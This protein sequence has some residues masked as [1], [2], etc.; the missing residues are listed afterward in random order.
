MSL[1]Y[2]EFKKIVPEET[3]TFFEQLLPLIDYYIGDY[4]D[5][6]IG[7]DFN[8]NETI[9]KFFLSIYCLGNMDEYSAFLGLLGYD[10]SVLE[11]EE[12]KLEAK[13]NLEDLYNKY[14]YL[15]PNY[16]DKL[17]YYD[18][19]P[20]DIVYETYLSFQR[21]CNDDYFNDILTRTNST[22]FGEKLR[23]LNKEKKQIQERE[24][25]KEIYHQVPINIISYL[26]TASKIR[27]I[28]I[29][30]LS[31]S[32]NDICKCLDND[33]VPVSLLLA[34]F[35]ENTTQNQNSYNDLSAIVCLLEENDITLD[36]IQKT[37]EINISS[38][39]LKSTPKNTYAIKELLGFILIVLLLAW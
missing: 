19:Q 13:T 29:G 26:E 8:E 17:S 4:N 22:S 7:T 21:C 24:L 20:T 11:V 23:N 32:K 31:A 18:L 2:N 6:Q 28:L 35:H 14:N 36:K 34:L 3:S 25:E 10:N 30:I 33:I 1:T 5:L 38:N 39:N 12:V 16:K 37:L 15:I 9:K 27:T